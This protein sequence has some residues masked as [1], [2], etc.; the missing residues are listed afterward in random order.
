MIKS[1][2][3][4]LSIITEWRSGTVAV[5]VAYSRPGL[6]L[7]FPT[8]TI[9]SVSKTVVVISLRSGVFIADLSNCEIK[10]GQITDLPENLREYLQKLSTV[11]AFQIRSNDGG[12]IFLIPVRDQKVL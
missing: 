10:Y 11:P 8:G 1:A 3:E 7:W 2:E 4:A 5:R 9:E 12:T 6:A